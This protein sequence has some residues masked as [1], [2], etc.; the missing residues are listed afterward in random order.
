MG[1]MGYEFIE[2]IEL[3]APVT[4]WGTYAI[5]D[6]GG[7]GKWRGGV[8]VA[9]EVQPRDHDMRI[10]SA[11]TGHTCAP[12]GLFGGMPGAVADHWIIDHD[13]GKV[14]KH[15][16]NASDT[17]CKPNQGWRAYTGGDGGFGDPLER[18]P[19]AVRDDARDG[20]VSLKAAKDVYGVA[21]N[22]EPELARKV[23][24]EKIAEPLKL[25]V[26]KAALGIYQVC[27]ENMVGGMLEM[28][29]R[30]GI[31][32]REF[33]IVTAG[34]ATSMFAAGLAL[35]I[36]IEWVIIPKEKAVLCSFGALN[37]DIALSAVAS[38]YTSTKAFDYDGINKVLEELEAKGEAFLASLPPGE[39]KLEYHCAARYPMQITEL[40]VTLS[41]KRVNPEVAQLAEDFHK[42][43]LARYKASDT[44][45]DVEFV[46]WRHVATSV[47]PR[48]ELAKQAR[49]SED[50]SKALMGRQPLYFE[51]QEDFIETP[52][53]DGDKLVY[54]MK[55]DGPALI[56]LPNTTII[57]PP[58]FKVSTQECGYFVMEVP[59]KK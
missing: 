38:R 10:I 2:I 9:H 58:E 13:T 42:A 6:S 28:T 40:E 23:I 52:F 4:L 36:G 15:L 1:N 24:K 34:G 29:V 39:R 33:V 57:V 12:Y 7:P 32:P 59:I 43:S 18:D 3:S 19:E 54:G 44:G 22:T 37:A 35:E 31:D 17:I 41:D 49:S 45:S 46:M 53:Y 27:K 21:I 26:E 11:A 5:T 51:G 30:R 56:T 25:T 14:A 20:F 48:I 47:T 8:A 50:P 55:V 16:E